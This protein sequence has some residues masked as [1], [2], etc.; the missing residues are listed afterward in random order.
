MKATKEVRPKRPKVDRGEDLEQ[1]VRQMFKL[2]VDTWCKDK[3]NIDEVPTKEVRGSV[4]DNLTAS[5]TSAIETIVDAATD[6]YLSMFGDE[7][8]V[9]C[10]E[11][12]HEFDL[13]D[14]Y[15]GLDDEEIECPECKHEFTLDDEDDPEET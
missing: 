9:E 2:Q 14:D 3:D 10:P 4:V 12:K 15:E 11:C 5:F 1:L 7:E 8:A 13:P 6:S